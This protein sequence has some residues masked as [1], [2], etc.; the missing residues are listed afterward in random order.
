MFVGLLI[1]NLNFL[2][3]FTHSNESIKGAGKVCRDSHDLERYWRKSLKCVLQ[4]NPGN[5][6]C[7]IPHMEQHISIDVRNE[8]LWGI[9]SC[10]C[11]MALNALVCDSI[12]W[13]Y[14]PFSVV[15]PGE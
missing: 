15:F 14:L 7:Y 12:A 6:S 9:L 1:T 4:D 8:I 2:N 11:D 5:H 10:L 13:V 3:R